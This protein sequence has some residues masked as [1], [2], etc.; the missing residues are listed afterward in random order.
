M[1]IKTYK[2]SKNVEEVFD[3]LPKEVLNN[4]T[5]NMTISDVLSMLDDYEAPIRIVQKYYDY[6]EKLKDTNS[7]E[8]EKTFTIVDEYWQL[9]EK[10]KET[11]SDMIKTVFK[12]VDEFWRLKIGAGLTAYQLLKMNKTLLFEFYL[13]PKFL[14][15]S[16]GYHRE[17]YQWRDK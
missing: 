8:F 13:N 9:K 14:N 7:E 11:D 10:L 2:G 3:D 1:K 15:E 4:I 6:K 16:K 5:S 12:V 17:P